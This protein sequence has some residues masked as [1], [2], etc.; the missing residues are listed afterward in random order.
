ML[1]LQNINFPYLL[2][3]LSQYWEAIKETVKETVESNVNTLNNS[4]QQLGQYL[5]IQNW[6]AQNQGISLVLQVLNWGVNHPILSLVVLVIALS[7]MVSII[8]RISNLIEITVWSIFQVPWK[9]LQLL[10]KQ[11]FRYIVNLANLAVFRLTGT[12]LTDYLPSIITKALPRYYTNKKQRLTEIY[13][14]LEAINIEQ[15]A[16]LQEAAQLIASEKANIKLP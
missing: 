4:T 9:L 2:V 7:L 1:I 5:S 6:L 3:D 11:I 14:R 12:Q 13:H 16:L 8:K 15:N 10:C